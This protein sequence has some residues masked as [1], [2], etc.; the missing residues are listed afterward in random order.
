MSRPMQHAD[1]AEIGEP[2]PLTA[3]DWVAQ[4]VYADCRW[5]RIQWRS[6]RPPCCAGRPCV[7]SLLF[8]FFNPARYSELHE[9]EQC[10]RCG[11]MNIAHYTIT[12][13]TAT[14]QIEEAALKRLEGPPM[15]TT[16]EAPPHAVLRRDER[17]AL[18]EARQ[19]LRA[20]GERLGGCAQVGELY[21]E[22]GTLLAEDVERH[23]SRDEQTRRQA[24]AEHEL[25]VRDEWLDALEALEARND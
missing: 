20:Y 13:L 25:S 10:D 24:Q 4:V 5:W 8:A 7:G 21:T 1:L 19:V 23:W 3:G 14:G 2:Q 6:Y 9:A 17:K 12:E 11:G 18:I 22:I 15:T 16:N